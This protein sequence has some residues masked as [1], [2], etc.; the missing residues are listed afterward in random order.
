MDSIFIK[1]PV[2]ERLPKN[3]GAYIIGYGT[4]KRFVDFNERTNHDSWRM[5]FEWWL[6]E[7]T[8]P[9]EEEIERDIQELA[10]SDE[11]SINDFSRQGLQYILNHIKKGG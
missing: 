8:L 9:T 3:Y 2:S 10:Y 5:N 6:E 1:V 4:T 7:I 11:M